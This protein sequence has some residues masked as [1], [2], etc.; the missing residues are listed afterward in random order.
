M[1]SD[2][3]PYCL[4]GSLF[5]LMVLP[6]VTMSVLH[7]SSQSLGLFFSLLPVIISYLL[8]KFAISSS[9]RGLVIFAYSTSFILTIILIHGTASAL[10]QDSFDYSRFW[11]SLT[12]MV[13]F[14][15]GAFSSC[16]LVQRFSNLQV[17]FAAKVVSYGMFL[18][19]VLGI[20]SAGKEVVFYSEPSH[21]SLNFLPCVLFMVV[22][23]KPRMKIV[24]LL[25]SCLLALLLENLTLVVGLCLIYLFTLPLKRLV[26]VV[27]ALILILPLFAIEFDY[28]TSRLDL[29]N[30]D[31][32]LSTLVY[33]QGWEHAYINFIDT[34]GLGVGFQQFG[35]I[36]RHGSISETIT[37]IIG[38]DMN[39][40]DGGS[41]G[42]KFIGEFGFI[43]VILLI[44][45]LVNFVKSAKLL[46]K[47]SMSGAM[48]IDYCQIF[49]LSCFVMYFVDIF[50]RGI[51]YFSS[52][53]LL[54]WTSLAWKVSAKPRVFVI[55]D[56]INNFTGS[57]RSGSEFKN[58]SLISEVL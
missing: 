24:W 1:R 35:V 48:T 49:L 36:G 5:V 15:L 23:S 33:L 40:L 8:L 37:K 21:Y 32:N 22:I 11:S 42:A 57:R 6:S 47:I 51:S 10:L 16:E 26:L 14:V 50:V 27:M 2:F 58:S 44:V 54:F 3:W 4:G 41:M 30:T 31:K 39:L 53:G 45:Y 25:S 12:L 28:Y 17:A 56:S 43:G 46:R 7:S 9:S 20:N 19:G 18:T 52:S 13:L 55:R 34:H 38:R 29:T